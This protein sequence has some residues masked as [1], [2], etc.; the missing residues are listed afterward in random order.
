MATPPKEPTPHIREQHRAL[1]NSLPFSDTRDFDD[2]RRGFIDKLDPA[3]VTDD[4]GRV[5]W[6]NDSYDFLSGEAP[7]SVN[8]SL[9]RVSTLNA[10]QG[11]FEVVPGIYQVRGLDIAVITFVEGETGVIVIDPLIS[12]ECAAAAYALY[13]KHRGQRPVTGVI[14]THSHIDHYGGVKGITTQEDV[15]AGRCVVL[16]PEGFTEHL[17]SELVYA[18]GAM[19]RR[20]A[21]MYA[22]AL[23]RGPRGQ[24]G[25]GLGQTNSTG[26]VTLIN[27]SRQITETGQEEVVDG[28]R[29]IFQLAPG[30]EAPAEMH[31]FFPDYAAL[32]VAE[33]ATHSLHNLLTLRGAQVRDPHAWAHYLGEMMEM[34]GADAEVIFSPHHWPTWGNDRV[35]EHIS[36]HRDLYAYLHDQTLRL[37]NKGFTGAEI[38]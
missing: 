16:A 5:V 26:T 2:A 6:D 24:V 17:V 28:V 27:P 7:E 37:L 34:F 36:L 31:F 29:M 10:M 18:G 19:A 35:L 8:P 12:A 20:A 15:D 38:A 23:D 14:Y 30:T 3:V 21:Y 13:A 9:W 4:S 25:A 11:L 1:L 22:A 32:C 33:N